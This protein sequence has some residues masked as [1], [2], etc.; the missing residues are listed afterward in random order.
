M[1]KGRRRQAQEDA[2]PGSRA[3]GTEAAD[4]DA[5]DTAGSD[6]EADENPSGRLGDA[7]TYAG[8]LLALAVVLGS[9]LLAMETEDPAWTAFEMWSRLNGIQS[10][11]TCMQA[12]D[13]DGARYTIAARDLVAESPVLRVPRAAILAASDAHN[14]SGTQGLSAQLAGHIRRL[15]DHELAPGNAT[16]STSRRMVLAV[17]L[18]WHRRVGAT[19]PTRWSAYAT[20]L[21][22]RVPGLPRNLDASTLAILQGTSALKMAEARTRRF[23]EEFRH[24]RHG[25]K[26][27]CKAKPWFEEHDY[28]W[29]RD[30]VDSRSFMLSLGDQA[31]EVAMVPFADLAD[32]ANENCALSHHMDE[33]G[34]FVA[35]SRCAFAKGDLV[36][37][38]YGEWG[39]SALMSQWGF[40]LDF[41]PFD[42]MAFFGRFLDTWVVDRVMFEFVN[43]GGCNCC[44]FTHG[45]MGMQDFM[46]L[47]S[48][49]ETDDG[50]TERRS[51]WPPFMQNEVWADRVKFRRMLKETM[52]I[53]RERFEQHG[54]DFVTWWLEL[55]PKERKRCFM[56]PKEELRV[57]FNSTY[58]FQTAYQVVLCSVLEQ[59]ENFPSTG[60][61]N[62]GGTD[63]EV[64]LE[65]H[66]GTKRGAWT[67]ADAYV[68]TDEGC[69]MFFGMLMQLGGDHLLPKRPTE[70][71]K[72]AAQAKRSVEEAGKDLDQKVSADDDDDDDEGEEE[73]EE[74]EDADRKKSTDSG[75]Q[76]FRGDRRLVRVL[77][78]RYFADMAWTR[79]KRAVLDNQETSSTPEEEGKLAPSASES[80]SACDAAPDASSPEKKT[81]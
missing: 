79:F 51:P 78:F 38:W 4:D 11:L 17:L 45:G 36:H 31:V 20:L 16:F 18:M 48:D 67:V 46:A 3:L 43:Q 30:M 12:Q 41:N 69:D 35:T 68:N 60:Y 39:N 5:G 70:S 10:E 34:D 23:K 37:N 73:A 72:Q 27:V 26:S 25:F 74:E 76:S 21:P 61:K 9:L 29:A 15:A 75:T 53:Y 71:R 65:T 2:A 64:F 42:S 24:L 52:G 44:G 58:D 80:A 57:Q 50:R 6:D 63:C 55:D 22:E 40:A 47:C 1:A 56:M 77:I 7:V 8:V 54:A 62:D 81:T 13:Q 32:H 59:V 33:N 28:V 19:R 49:V 66:L 14:V